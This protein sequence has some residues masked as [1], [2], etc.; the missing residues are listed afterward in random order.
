MRPLVLG[1]FVV[2]QSALAAND[3][4]ATPSEL[5]ALPVV[6]GDSDIGF[7][8]GYIM[9]YAAVPPPYQ[10]YLWRVESAG[11]MTF[12]SADGGGV[13][14]PYLDDYLWLHLPQVLGGKLELR[15]RVSYTRET[16]LK[17][18]GLGNASRLVEGLRASDPYYE[19]SRER[20]AL[21]W[22]ALY[23]LT[24]AVDLTWGMAYSYNRI[25]VPANTRLA[26]TMRSGSA[27]EREL[28]GSARDHGS[29]QF[30]FGAA[31]DTRDSYV[32]TRRGVQVLIRADLAPGGARAM[33][34]GF[35]R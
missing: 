13:R 5:T 4:G 16:N 12:K 19:H 24:A 32:N 31:Y 35:A 1:L 23:H 8:G 29:A 28:L 9:S 22:S 10:P 30:S 21:R 2:L 34:Y 20:P 18:T 11:I 15:A 14:V 6:D 7:G 17:F 25:D 33:P 26:E 27:Y 3:A